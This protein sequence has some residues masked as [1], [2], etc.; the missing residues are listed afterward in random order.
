MS[1]LRP[2]NNL[3]PP[4]ETDNIAPIHQLKEHNWAFE[5]CIDEQKLLTLNYQLEIKGK[6][7]YFEARLSPIDD[8]SLLAIIRDISLRT[9]LNI[10]V[11]YLSQLQ[12]LLTQ[13]ANQFINLE[14]SQ[15]NQAINKALK[16]IGEFMQADRTYVFSYDWQKKHSDQHL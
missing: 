14:A 5:Q 4:K 9:E 16:E 15:V 8:K 6:T 12:N 2:I 13:L 10:Q 1:Y 3:N 7:Y 11:Q